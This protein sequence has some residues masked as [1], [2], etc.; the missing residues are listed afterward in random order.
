MQIKRT[1]PALQERDKTNKLPNSHLYMK[2]N[3]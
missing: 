2:F 1:F 3:L